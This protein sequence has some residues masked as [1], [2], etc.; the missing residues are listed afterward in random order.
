[1]EEWLLKTDIFDYAA[2]KL[3]MLLAIFFPLL[4]FLFIILPVVNNFP[5]KG[6]KETQVEHIKKR[7][8]VAWLVLFFLLPPI[9]IFALLAG[10][11]STFFN[12]TFFSG[13]IIL[14]GISAFFQFI[15]K[16]WLACLVFFGI[17]FLYCLYFVISHFNES[18]NV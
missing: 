8:Y 11:F 17:E 18:I 13:S 14:I 4:L 2:V 7:L 5:F 16:I 6:S 9:Y 15:G 12:Y 10:G 1:M 3:S